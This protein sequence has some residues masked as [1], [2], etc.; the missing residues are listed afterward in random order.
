MAQ[1]RSFRERLTKNAAGDTTDILRYPQ[2]ERVPAGERHHITRSAFE[3]ETTACT[4]VQ[5]NIN[6]GGILYAQEEQL[7][8]VAG[9]LYWIDQE[10]VLMEG[11]QL[12]LYFSGATASDKLK[13]YVGGYV[14]P[15][16]EEM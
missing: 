15:T 2:N 8:P 14:T 16:R 5:I 11:E 3:D 10:M 12:E 4:E 7:S 1:K 6:R 13:A 9:Y